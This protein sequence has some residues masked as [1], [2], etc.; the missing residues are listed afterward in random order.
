MAV[1]GTVAS[2]IGI[3]YNPFIHFV[4]STK[5][6]WAEIDPVELMAAGEDVLDRPVRNVVLPPVSSVLSER[7][8]SRHIARR[9]VQVRDSVRMRTSAGTRDGLL[10]GLASSVEPLS[11]T[12]KDGRALRLIRRGRVN[13]RKTIW[14]RWQTIADDVALMRT[15]QTAVQPKILRGDGRRPSTVGIAPD[16]CDVILTSPPYPNNIDYTEVY[17][18]ELWLMGL[19]SSTD[20]FL[21]LRSRTFRSHPTT[22]RDAPAAEFIR[23]ARSPSLRGVL[24]PLIERAR[25]MREPWRARL[26][27]GYFEDVYIALQ[28]YH[29]I[30]RPGGLAIFIVGN[31][32]HGGS[33]DPYVIPTDIILAECARSCG[34]EVDRAIIARGFRRRLSGNHFLRETIVV[35]RKSDG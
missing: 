35:L 12:R 3:E 31:S 8:I 19:V 7:C 33:S 21:Q 2:A 17:K 22:V 34:F 29:E 14:D 11:R 20:E 10:L 24:W 25:G 18:L 23:L 26:L 9:I 5:T 16:S 6:R 32:L 15:T 13:V 4:A 30:L 28:E 27:L 1:D